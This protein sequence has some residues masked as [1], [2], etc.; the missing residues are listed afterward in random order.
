MRRQPRSIH[1]GSDWTTEVSSAY[2][3][4][5]FLALVFV[6][7]TLLT[8]GPLVAID[9]FFNIRTPPPGW[10]PVLHVLDRMGQRAVCLP[11]LGIAVYRVVRETKS[12]RPIIVVILSVLAL[13]FVVGILKIGLG[14]GEPGTGDPSFFVGGMAFPSGHTSNMVLVYGLMPY[15]LTS[16]GTIHRRTAYI[17]SVA[18]VALSLLMVGVSLTLNWHW[19]ADLIG[20]LLIGGMVLSLTSG[21]DHAIPLD[22]FARGWRDGLRRIPGVIL[23]SGSRPVPRRRP[24]QPH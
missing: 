14:R 6:G 9:G 3:L 7:F 10:V 11:V 15:L 21:I 24:L 12:W 20:G 4:A 17:L 1:P 18:V 16:Y 5:G 2:A 19:F 23:T 22:I 8:M 13:N